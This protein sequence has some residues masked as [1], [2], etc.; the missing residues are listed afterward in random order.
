V[1]GHSDGVPK[2]VEAL[3]ISLPIGESLPDKL[4]AKVGCLA[5]GIINQ[6]LDNKLSLFLCQE[7]RGLRV[8]I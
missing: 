1:N 7:G 3:Y 4:G 6:C 2:R 5:F 8:L